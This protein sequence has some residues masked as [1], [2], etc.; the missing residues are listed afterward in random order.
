MPSDLVGACCFYYHVLH[1]HTH[2]HVH[3]LCCG[4]VV[5]IHV[6]WPAK[7]AGVGLNLAQ[8]AKDFLLTR[9]DYCPPWARVLGCVCERSQSCPQIHLYELWAP[10]ARMMA[11]NNFVV[12]E[13]FFMDR[14]SKCVCVCVSH[15]QWSWGSRIGL[16]ITSHYPLEESLQLTISQCM[17][18]AVTFHTPHIPS[19]CSRRTITV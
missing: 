4:S 8:I 19:F 9:S 5:I 18:K 2:T 10:S 17:G 1:T 16:V 11:D 15:S 14:P 3:I 13:L 7:P 12:F 6:I